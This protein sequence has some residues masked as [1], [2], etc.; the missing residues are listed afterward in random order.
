MSPRKGS[1]RKVLRT[2]GD[3]LFDECP[4]LLQVVP[5][6]TDDHR[7]IFWSTHPQDMLLDYQGHHSLEARNLENL[8]QANWSDPSAFEKVDAFGMA[9]FHILALYAKPSL[10]DPRVLP[11][12]LRLLSSVPPW[13]I[14]LHLQSLNSKSDTAS[15][16]L[17]LASLELIVAICC[18]LEV[19]SGNWSIS[20]EISCLHLLGPKPLKRSSSVAWRIDLITWIEFGPRFL[21]R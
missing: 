10:D 16:F 12:D 8:K 1:G 11:A 7:L 6:E 9:P 18:S 13:Y 19:K 4:K 3:E 17:Y 14:C 20:F 2:F 21:Q 5:D 15:R